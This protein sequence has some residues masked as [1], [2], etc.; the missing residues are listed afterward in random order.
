M[1]EGIEKLY[2]T[3]ITRDATYIFGGAAPLA[4]LIYA[5]QFEH[6]FRDVPGLATAAFLAC[7]YVLGFALFHAAMVLPHPQLPLIRMFPQDGSC[8]EQQAVESHYVSSRL[9]E[10]QRFY[11]NRYVFLKH[12]DAVIVVGAIALAVLMLVH[13][14]DRP[15][16][17][18]YSLSRW[19]WFLRVWPWLIVLGALAL[20]S[21]YQNR[22]HARIQQ[23][24]LDRWAEDLGIRQVQRCPPGQPG[25]SPGA[26]CAVP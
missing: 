22:R 18:E 2:T 24:L 20:S 5:Y 7:A 23:G 16:F 3:L 14:A 12:C 9:N 8:S 19:Q 6:L 13:P 25:C 10:T 17:P 26:I 1:L 21:G 4:Y 11:L 15:L